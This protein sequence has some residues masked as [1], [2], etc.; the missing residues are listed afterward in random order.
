MTSRARP[1]ESKQASRPSFPLA[2]T[3]VTP[4]A[5]A[6]FAALSSAEL[7]GPPTLKLITAFSLFAFARWKAR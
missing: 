5:T 2:T 6:A 4:F 7:A 1:G 3:T